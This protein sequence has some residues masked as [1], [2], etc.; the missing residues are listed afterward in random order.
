MSLLSNIS[1]IAI[2]LDDIR[3]ILRRYVE[4]Q[5]VR[6]PAREQQEEP[7]PGAWSVYDPVLEGRLEERA[8]KMMLDG[9]FASFDDAYEEAIKEEAGK[10]S[11]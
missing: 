7:E 8:N 3:D 1:K 6:L 5:G 2:A 11:R 10:P 4:Q 9:R